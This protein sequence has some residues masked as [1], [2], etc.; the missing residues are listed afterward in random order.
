MVKFL[1]R[2]GSKQKFSGPRLARLEKKLARLDPGQE[3]WARY[4]SIT[5]KKVS[6]NNW[7]EVG[8]KLQIGMAFGWKSQECICCPKHSRLG[9]ASPK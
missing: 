4:T 5:K 7:L 8:Q 3:K 6:L 9:S 1:A 2:V